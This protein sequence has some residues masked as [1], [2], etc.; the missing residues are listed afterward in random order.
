M[1]ALLDA[2]DR[3]ELLAEP[4]VVISNNEHSQGLVMAKE[5]KVEAICI[6]SQGKSRAEHERLVIEQIERRSCRLICLAGYMK[7]LSS[8]FVQR[9][10]GRILNIHPSLL[11]AFPGLRAQ[12]QALNYGVR[13]TGCTV[14]FVDEGCDTG[15][16]ILQ[17]VVP[18]LE[19]DTEESLA[20]RILEQEHRI[21]PQAVQMVLDGKFKVEGR[22]VIKRV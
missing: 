3:G 18:V 15:P 10:R 13:Y 1:L 19:D 14:H 12:Q 8:E 4:A 2:I 5:R 17:A 22:R 16:I 11:P 6:P 7:L 21:Y 9:F 20:A